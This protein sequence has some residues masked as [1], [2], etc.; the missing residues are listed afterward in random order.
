MRE[1]HE[2]ILESITELET[3]ALSATYHRELITSVRR[4]MLN[5]VSELLHAMSPSRQSQ[6]RN[7]YS[8]LPFAYSTLNT[9]TTG[10]TS[11]ADVC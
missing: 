8:I 10:V 6:Y 5:D 2:K 1:Q 4:H 9:I 3:Q 7:L 11:A